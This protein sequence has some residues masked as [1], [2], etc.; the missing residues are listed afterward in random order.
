MFQSIYDSG[1][2]HPFVAWLGVAAL[3]LALT[4]RPPGFLRTFLIVFGVEIAVDALCTGALSP[5]PPSVL[6]SVSIVF[7][8]AGD[9]RLFL[10]VERAARPQGAIARSLGL[11]FVVPVLQAIAIKA[12]PALFAEPRWIYL[13]YELLFVVLALV[14]RFAILPKRIA[15]PALRRWALGCVSW[16]IVGYSL[17]ATADVIIL[18]GGEWGLL[19]RLIPNAMYYAGFLLFVAWTAPPEAWR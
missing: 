4:K 1:W 5:V 12:A 13:V 19:L 14:L 16:F 11:A 18:A 3:A 15:D 6:S 2:H 17:W 9:W 7:V 10:L 8:I